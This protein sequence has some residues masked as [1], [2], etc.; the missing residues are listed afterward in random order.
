ME[1]KSM[2]KIIYLENV[3][4]ILSGNPAEPVLG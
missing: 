3:V 1:M 2:Y 4:L